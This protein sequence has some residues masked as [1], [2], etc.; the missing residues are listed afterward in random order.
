MVRII[1]R[2]S[3]LSSTTAILRIREIGLHASREG[4]IEKI[5]HAAGGFRRESFGRSGNGKFP[6]YG[7]R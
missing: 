4:L 5:Y 7:V 3:E 6:E 2:L 1:N